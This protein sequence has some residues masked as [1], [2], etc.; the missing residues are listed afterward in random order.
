MFQ[1]VIQ[2]LRLLPFYRSAVCHEAAKA[3]LHLL[4]SKEDISNYLDILSYLD[5]PEYVSSFVIHQIW[6]LL[7]ICSIMGKFSTIWN[8]FMNFLH[9]SKLSDKWSVLTKEC[10]K[11]FFKLS[12]LK[13]LKVLWQSV[14]IWWSANQIIIYHIYSLK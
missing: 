14:N 7:K 1:E 8:T 3:T 2:G 9:S 11:L 6:F 12:V 10:P 13:F 5:N 4:L